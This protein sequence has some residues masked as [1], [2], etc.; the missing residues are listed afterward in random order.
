[1]C[2]VCRTPTPVS[3]SPVRS[4]LY[5][6]PSLHLCML[7]TMQQRCNLCGL[8]ST[9]RCNACKVVFYCGR[10]HQKDDWPK[11]KHACREYQRLK[12][13]GQD[14]EGDIREGEDGVLNSVFSS[15][16]FS[17]SSAGEYAGT[18]RWSQKFDFTQMPVY[19]SP[20]ALECGWQDFFQTRLGDGEKKPFVL[21]AAL[22]D[23]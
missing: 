14:F 17:C 15:Q 8:P 10:S 1:M 9:Q 11:H 5:V 19:Q 3:A 6:A 23:G 7:R 4:G 16:T 20:A 13:K 2:D 22:I 21:D 12:S 18:F